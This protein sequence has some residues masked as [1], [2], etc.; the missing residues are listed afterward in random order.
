MR[1]A[2][3]GVRSN[4]AVAQLSGSI[5]QLFKTRHDQMRDLIP[6]WFS[7]SSSFFQFELPYLYICSNP[8]PILDPDRDKKHR[9]GKR[10]RD[11]KI[12]A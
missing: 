12:H 1:D 10:Q 3:A 9:N 11:G 8:L 2:E 6:Q 5:V 4:A 7:L